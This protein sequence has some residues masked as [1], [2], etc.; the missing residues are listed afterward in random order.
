MATYYHKTPKDRYFLTESLPDASL[1]IGARYF[2][3]LTTVY[4]GGIDNRSLGPLERLIVDPSLLFGVYIPPPLLR[5]RG[6]LLE[7]VDVSHAMEIISLLP[8]HLFLPL[9]SSLVHPFMHSAPEVEWISWVLLH[10]PR[11]PHHMQGGGIEPLRARPSPSPCMHLEVG[12]FSPWV[13][14]RHPCL[15]CISM[16]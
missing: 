3:C 4:S 10:H 14:A 6:C 5:K 9:S 13:L 16:R 7:R 1:G 11:H 12:G 15:T 8:L 2:Q